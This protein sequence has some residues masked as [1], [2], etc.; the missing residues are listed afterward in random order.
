MLPCRLQREKVA[1]IGEVVTALFLYAI[2]KFVFF[3]LPQGRHSD[4]DAA[5]A[6]ADYLELDGSLR[7]HFLLHDC[8]RYVAVDIVDPLEYLSLALD[9]VVSALEVVAE[10]VLLAGTLPHEGGDGA[11]EDHL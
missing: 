4:E 11:I 2:L 7:Q 6:L 8:N 5:L 1:A 10:D 9:Q 3:Y